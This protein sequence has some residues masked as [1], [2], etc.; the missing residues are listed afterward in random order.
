MNRFFTLL[1]TASCLT[2]VGQ[3]TYPYNPDEDGNGLIGVPDLQ[4]LLALY[5][6]AFGIQE[7]NVL[8]VDITEFGSAIDTIALPNEV[9]VLNLNLFSEFLESEESEGFINEVRVLLPSDSSMKVLQVY[10][11]YKVPVLTFENAINWQDQGNT[12][13]E[14]VFRGD[15]LIGNYTDAEN[16]MGQDGIATLLCNYNGRP[17]FALLFR[18]CF[19][20]WWKIN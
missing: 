7:P 2:A 13:A 19:G 11:R 4:G 3:V 10:A 1:L 16:F 12:Y 9:D 6:G 14:V 20:R 15:Q 5:G 17:K 18:D 8:D